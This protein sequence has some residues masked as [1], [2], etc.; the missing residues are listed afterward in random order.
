MMPALLNKVGVAVLNNKY[1]NKEVKEYF[2]L[3]NSN[4]KMTAIMAIGGALM[5]ALFSS[6]I[7]G[8][9]GI[10]PSETSKMLI[11]LLSVAIIPEALAVSLYQVLQT[12]N[13]M[14]ASFFWVALPRDLMMMI[15]AAILIPKWS[16]IGWAS[17]YGLGW[18]LAMVVI[19]I[20]VIRIKPKLML[21][22]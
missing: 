4:V 22:S 20:L 2:S 15:L 9:Y 19:I 21:E 5:M 10:Q 14:W 18:L 1:G 8:W 13:R 3:Y 7:P 12:G 6:F 17:A 16:A 11:L